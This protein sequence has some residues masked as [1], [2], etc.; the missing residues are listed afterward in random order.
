MSMDAAT[1][2]QIMTEY[3]RTEGDTGSPEVQVAMLTHRINHL[4]EHLKEHKHDHH[5][6]RGL[7]LMVG[8]RRRLLNYLATPTSRATARSSSGSACAA[9]RTTG[10]APRSGTTS[11]PIH[12]VSPRDSSVLGRGFRASSPRAS[13]DDRACRGDPA[14]AL[15]RAA[16]DGPARDRRDRGHRQR[17]FGTRTIRFETG[18]LAQ[19]AAGSAVAYLDDETML[20]GHDRR[21]APQG[22]L[23]LLPADGRRRG[24]DVRRG[25][26]PRLVLPP[27]GPPVRGRDPHL[28]AHRP[29][30]APVLRQGPAQ[31]GPGRHHVMALDP[32]DLY[33]VSRSTPRR[34]PPSCPACRSPARSAPSASPHRRPVGRLPDARAA[35]GAPCSTWSSPAGSPDGDVAIMMVEAEAT[36]STSSSSPAAPPRRPRRSWPRA[37]RP[38]SRSSRRCARPS[39]AGRARPP[40]R[41]RTSRV[42]LD[43]ED[44]AYDAVERRPGR[45]R[46]GAARSPASRAR[47]RA[48]RVKASVSS[49]SAE[50]FEGR[51][52]ELSAPRS[53]R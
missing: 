35:R 32:D 42:F 6:R 23:R 34:C 33:D 30:A 16:H 11:Y 20:L 12:G 44:D 7:L 21:Q 27:R 18:R 25:Q 50:Q 37:S 13:I 43:Y 41:P 36:E 9:S 52:K 29:P 4:T 31:R 19:Q 17:R 47:G 51:E 28:P 49:S 53:A 26:D 14:R 38:P 2:Q 10:T 46:R 15:R 1:K 39:R 22:A 5:S 48:R 8:R 3:A 24:A 40:R 45:P